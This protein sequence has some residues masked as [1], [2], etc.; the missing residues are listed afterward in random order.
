MKPKKLIRSKIT[1]HLRPDEWELVSTKSELNN[2]YAMKIKEELLEIQ[3]S[4]HEDIM[5]FV[6]LIEVACCFAEQNGFSRDELVAKLIEKT[7]KQGK[8]GKIALTNLNPINP[9]NSIYFNKE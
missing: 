7:N 5:E 1:D 8:F 4:E 9:S 3:S 2:L 6:D